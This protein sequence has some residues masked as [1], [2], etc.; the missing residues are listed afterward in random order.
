MTSLNIYEHCWMPVNIYRHPRTSLDISRHPWTSLD[1]PGHTRTSLDIPGY[2]WTSLGT[3]DIPGHRW[4][5]LDILGHPWEHLWKWMVVS[6]TCHLLKSNE[7]YSTNLV[8][9]GMSNKGGKTPTVHMYWVITKLGKRERGK[10][11]FHC[12]SFYSKNNDHHF[13]K[14]DTFMDTLNEYRA[15]VFKEEAV[16]FALAFVEYLQCKSYMQKTWRVCRNLVCSK[17][18]LG[19]WYN[20]KGNTFVVHG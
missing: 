1:I 18:I 19:H 12:S 17:L 16:C 6:L 20:E 2:P 8:R 4:T 15:F 5:S 9:M 7:I 14:S 3:L 11:S 10:M 13:A